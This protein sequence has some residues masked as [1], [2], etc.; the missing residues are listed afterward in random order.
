MSSDL[1][2]LLSFALLASTEL[3]QH[4]YQRLWQICKLKSLG[5]GAGLTEIRFAIRGPSTLKPTQTMGLKKKTV[6]LGSLPPS[7]RGRS[8][9]HFPFIFEVAD[10]VL[11]TYIYAKMTPLSKKDTFRFYP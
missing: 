6:S 4:V 11:G 10:F 8:I 2:V 1:L 3:I 5:L 7:C 9:Y